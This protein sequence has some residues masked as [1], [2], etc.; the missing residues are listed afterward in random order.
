MTNLS[1]RQFNL[2]TAG[3]V[4][5][6]MATALPFAA[7][8]Y[9]KNLTGFDKD[10][11]IDE[12]K[13]ARRQGQ[14]AVEH[15]IARAVSKPHDLLNGLSAPEKGKI[16]LLHRSP[17]LTIFNIVWPSYVVFA[18]HDHQMW[19]TI[20][21]YQG[22]EDNVLWDETAEGLKATQ[23]QSLA[24]GDI[25]SLSRDAIHSVINPTTQYT[26]AIHIYGG[27]LVSVERSQ[28]D[29]ATHREEPFDVEDGRQIMKAADRRNQT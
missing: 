20:G 3:A 14:G 8:A 28:W 22:R 5:A 12:V 25:F 26:A 24:T 29:P 9:A 4:G 2:T 10:R 15:V 16:E 1:R 6:A 11:F 18:P 27:D 23:A 13:G 17:D 19:A 7:P 21:V